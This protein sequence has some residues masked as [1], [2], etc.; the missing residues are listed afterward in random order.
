LRAQRHRLLAGW[1]FL[2]VASGGGNLIP[3]NSE[4]L[5]QDHLKRRTYIQ[6]KVVRAPDQQKPRD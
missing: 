2:G 1:A 3:L 5:R 6:K 4:R